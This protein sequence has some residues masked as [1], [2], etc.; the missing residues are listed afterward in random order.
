MYMISVA[1]NW[2]R[3]SVPESKDIIGTGSEPGDG[4]VRSERFAAN[5]ALTSRRDIA[6]R[7]PEPAHSSGD[8]KLNS[9]S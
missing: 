5:I 2:K 3:I 6:G 8:K 1:E 7:A 9:R 4:H